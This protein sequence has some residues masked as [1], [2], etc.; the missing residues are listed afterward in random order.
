LPRE[1]ATREILESS[2]SEF[3]E[4]IDDVSPILPVLSAQLDVM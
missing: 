4:V 1:I 2:N 3:L